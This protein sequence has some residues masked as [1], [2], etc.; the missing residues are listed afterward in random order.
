MFR[1]CL[2]DLWL[3]FYGVAA[4]A[5]RYR[6]EARNMITDLD[7]QLPSLA[8]ALGRENLEILG[9]FTVTRDVPAGTVLIHDRQPVNAL[10]L[11][12]DGVFSASLEEDGRSMLVG[13][14]GKGK[15]VGEVSLF[16]RQ[17][18]ASSSVIAEVDGRV[19][20]LAHRDF[21]RLQIEHPVLAGALTRLLVVTLAERLRAS[22]EAL[23]LD[24]DGHV[25]LRGSERVVVSD[26]A[27][28]SGW[29]RTM[30]QKVLG[31]EGS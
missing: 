5:E 17:P 2:P 4:V 12:L 1:V 18:L 22:G 30:L 26:S 6:Y 10:Y 28:R 23:G 19:L 27:E 7:E 15:W 3:A 21:H 31:V 29:V 13:R 24:K 8:Q 20:E 25:I 14:L 9:S 16:N 11:I